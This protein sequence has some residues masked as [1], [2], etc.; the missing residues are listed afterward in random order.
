MDDKQIIDLYWARIEE[1]ISETASKYGR[2]CQSIACNILASREDSEECV[3]DTYLA[4]W[5]DIPPQ[6]PNRF[7][8]F[9]GRITRNLALK[10]YDYVSA[11][12]RN[13]EAIC[14]LDELGDCVSGEESAESELENQRIEE[15]IDQFLW[16]QGK[17]KRQVF[18]L[19]YWYF[20]SIQTICL[21][22]GYS[23][24]K[25]KSMLFELRQKLRLHLESEGIEL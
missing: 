17:E 18:V 7:S 11:E 6:R 21:R 19:R 13:P 9:I 14:S 20:A 2:L 4:L 5:D 8:A 22:T 23:Q 25:V 15:A 24:S 12:K 1:A 10:K 3:N 16:Q